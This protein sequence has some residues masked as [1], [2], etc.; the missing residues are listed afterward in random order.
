MGLLKVR[1]GLGSMRT[2]NLW[3]VISLAWFAVVLGVALYVI[4]V[5]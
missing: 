1:R 3:L 5:N 4:I 2:D